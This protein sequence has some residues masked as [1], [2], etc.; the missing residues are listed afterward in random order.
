MHDATSEGNDFFRCDFCRRGWCDELPMVEGHR[1]SLICAECLT[2]AVREVLVL[3]AGV[4]HEEINICTMCLQH[5]EQPHW[6]SPSHAE[7]AICAWC[8]EKSATMLERD[9]EIGWS[10][11]LPPR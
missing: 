9:P 1:G 8:I 11:P 4:A 5:K 7:C 2:D 3:S 6:R 10:R